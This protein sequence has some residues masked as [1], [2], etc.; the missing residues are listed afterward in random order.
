MS[1]HVIIRE[2]ENVPDTAGYAAAKAPD[3]AR[4]FVFSSNAAPTVRLQ[5]QIKFS[6][7]PCALVSVPHIY[8]DTG[9]QFFQ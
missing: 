2:L 3:R 5:T 4:I 8:K 6:T 1:H 7:L 9:R